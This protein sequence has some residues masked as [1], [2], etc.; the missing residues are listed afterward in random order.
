MSPLSSIK[1]KIHCINLVA[2]KLNTLL[3]SQKNTGCSLGMLES[4]RSDRP[5]MGGRGSSRRSHFVAGALLGALAGVASPAAALE[6]P[7]TA[8]TRIEVQ[9]FW[10]SFR[11]A[12]L[13]NDVAALKGMTVLPLK[14]VSDG[15]TLGHVGSAG[16]TKF[17]TAELRCP[18]DGASP[19]A[20]TISITPNVKPETL[21]FF[22]LSNLGFAKV[23]A[24][25]RLQSIECL[26]LDEFKHRT[27]GQ[28]DIRT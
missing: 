22:E 8:A 23:G 20:Q 7:P 17:F 12:V 15:A 27:E 21:R 28:C 14:I 25:W 26:G 13:R 3:T 9:A 4:L 5:A 2:D 1:L 19:L 18:L 16:F 6:P 11:A 10:S 24:K